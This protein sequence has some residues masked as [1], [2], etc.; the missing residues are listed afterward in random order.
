[1]FFTDRD[2]EETTKISVKGLLKK[3]LSGKDFY[4]HQLFRRDISFFLGNCVNETE[5]VH[6]AVKKNLAGTLHGLFGN[7]GR[8]LSAETKDAIC[9]AYLLPAMLN[10]CE[11]QFPNLMDSLSLYSVVER[12]INGMSPR[13]IEGVFYGF[14]GPYFK[15]IILYGW[16]GLFAGLLSYALGW[17]PPLRP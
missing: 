2:A 16:I 7:A 3:I 12:E 15:K 8:L 9:G 5:A 14:A 1:M 17:L 13:E 6:C 11:N 4:D 10:A